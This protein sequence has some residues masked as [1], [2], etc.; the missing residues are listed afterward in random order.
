[1]FIS[2]RG[3]ADSL[4]S[5]PATAR[6]ES[7]DESFHQAVDAATHQCRYRSVPVDNILAIDTRSQV[8]QQKSSCE[9]TDFPAVAVKRLGFTALSDF[10]A[11]S[12]TLVFARGII[13][14][15]AT[16]GRSRRA[17]I[18]I[19]LGR[20]AIVPISAALLQSGSGGQSGN[21]SHV[22]GVTPV[23]SLAPA[24]GIRKSGQTVT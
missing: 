15:C 3:F 11:E 19:I 16:L 12:I 18:C 8:P 10:G 4:R 23:E 6:I 17:L 21:W 2:S 13:P 1:M 5:K 24:T 22:F 9:A 14:G 20:C 7:G